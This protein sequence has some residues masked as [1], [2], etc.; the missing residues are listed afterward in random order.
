MEQDVVEEPADPRLLDHGGGHVAA[1]ELRQQCPAPDALRVDLPGLELGLAEEQG[2]Q[3]MPRGPGTGDADHLAAKVVDSLD[4]LPRR[5]S[6]EER[7]R[8]RPH[9][10]GHD[11][12]TDPA[13]VRSQIGVTGQF[14]AV[15]DLLTGQENLQLMAALHHLGRAE[16]KERIEDLL[17]RFELTGAAPKHVATYSGGMK[18]QLDLAMTLMGNP[19][20]VFL[21]EPTSGV[22]PR[23]RRTM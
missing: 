8:R 20:I 16:A 17:A 3:E 7:D 10:G 4:R 15:N 1:P 6:D 18:R 14:S 13:G 19:R 5:R 22:D 2:Q 12:H 23:G 11:L 9:V 21:D